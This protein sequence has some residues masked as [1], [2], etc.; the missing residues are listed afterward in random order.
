MDNL[1]FLK[2]LITTDNDYWIV[3]MKN[4]D[5]RG[6]RYK[7]SIMFISLPYGRKIYS[8]EKEILLSDIEELRRSCVNNI[9]LNESYPPFQIGQDLYNVYIGFP[10]EF[11]GRDAKQVLIEA[12]NVNSTS[13]ADYREIA[14]GKTK[15]LATN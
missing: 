10:V 15:E 14:E 11:D 2:K 7:D 9:F 1:N 13:I 6:E 3:A 4:E 5:G 8:N 12:L